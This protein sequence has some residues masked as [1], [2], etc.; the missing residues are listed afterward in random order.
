MKK[1]VRLTAV[2]LMVCCICV[3]SVVPVAAA[4]NKTVTRSYDVTYTDL[5]I[6]ALD[7][8]ARDTF[9]ITYNGSKVVS[10]KTSQSKKDFGTGMLSKGGIKLKKKTAKVWTYEST[11][12]INLRFIPKSLEPV[13]VKYI[14][15]LVAIQKVGTIVKATTIYEV[16]ADGKLKTVKTTLKWFTTVAKYKKQIEKYFNI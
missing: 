6:K 7:G 4:S 3:Y 2:M 1:I 15:Q 12:S 8:Y 5:G 14:P 11:W 13:V 9:K 16:K 10:C